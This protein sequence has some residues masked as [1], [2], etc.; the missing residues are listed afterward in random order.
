MATNPQKKLEQELLKCRVVARQG[1]EI[2]K[3]C[4]QRVAKKGNTIMATNPQKKLELE[5]LK[6]RVV[7]RQGYEIAKKN[8]Q[9]MDQ[10]IESIS[11]LLL[12]DLKTLDSSKIRTEQVKEEL[13]KQLSSIINE[14]KKLVSTSSLALSE[15]SKQLDSFNITLFGRT[16]A[17]K[18]TLM[19][20][21]TNGT[22][23]SIG[24]GSQRTTRDVR[25]Y[26]WK[27]LKITD[28]PGVAAFEGE[29]DE[30]VAYTAASKADLV[31]FLITDDS[32][33]PVEAECLAKIINLGKPVLGICNVK[34][35][36]GDLLDIKL[37]L[38]SPEKV[39]DRTRLLGI[40]KQFN[41]FLAKYVPSVH[42]DFIPV[43]LLARYLGA[44]TK[45]INQ[46]EELISASRFS[47][48]ES[49][50]IN[51]VVGKGRFYR[52]K[53]FID[54]AVVPML[55]LIDQL[56]DFS[57]QNS[58]NG[59]A[60]ID[61]QRKLKTWKQEFE[62][63]SEK[64]IQTCVSRIMEELRKEIPFFVESHF[65]DTNAGSAWVRLLKSKDIEGNVQKLQ[66]QLT[67]ECQNKLREIA[68][69]LE[70]ETSLL[71]KFSMASEIRMD[72]IH[73]Y[74]KWWNWGVAIATGVLGIAAL[75]VSGPLG[76]A[77]AGISVLGSLFSFFFD[78]HEE[79]AKQA[80]DKLTKQLNTNINEMGEKIIRKLK[81][82]FYKNL[83]Q[84]Q[85]PVLMNNL[86][87][88]T[89][90]IFRLA[91]AQRSLAWM[92][93]ERQKK[94]NRELIEEALR[95]LDA[96][97]YF[98][99]I[100]D[101]ARKP[102]TATMFLIPPEFS[103]PQEIR[104]KLAGLLGE[105]IWFVIDTQNNFFLLKQAIGRGCESHKIRIEQKIKVA[106][107]PL[108]EFDPLTKERVKL[109]QQLTGLHITL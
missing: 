46:R 105:K 63:L 13:K 101:I 31:L 24:N 39:F 15:R 102:N 2:A 50:I 79:K 22:G 60:Y 76:W 57:A 45:Y 54:G 14:L 30:E 68:K 87:L 5:L 73:D 82:W 43:H 9:D 34:A 75:F 41:Q 40:N 47:E 59:R 95:Q 4:L 27:G 19:E 64:R 29:H 97:A 72:P 7:A 100:K 3:M 26:E 98:N 62:E 1:Y 61:S 51:V 90:G 21:L 84:E 107:V 80:R 58:S 18:S 91:D 12:R 17:G 85:V 103:M 33:Q 96:S 109:A 71:T 28:V 52:I 81:G 77:A 65:E 48:V 6:C 16:M 66:E 20:I 67:Q 92:L 32:P 94:L 99:S 42:V 44:Q 69:E 37:F 104:Y 53:S 10:D 55:Q 74:K 83:M 35:T 56:L 88:V 78:S 49:K 11:Q 36:I 25:S 89:D 70:T 8:I 38:R 93:N 108:N 23:A 106:H 86:K